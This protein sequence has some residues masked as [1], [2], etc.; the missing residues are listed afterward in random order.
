MDVKGTIHSHSLGHKVKRKEL[1]SPIQFEVDFS[2]TQCVIRLD[3]PKGHGAYISWG[4]GQSSTARGEGDI[5]PRALI[6]TSN[7]TTHKKYKV[8]LF[9]CFHRISRLDLTGVA[10]QPFLTADTTNWGLMESLKV[11]AAS[12]T[13]FTGTQPD[14][15][16]FKKL[17]ILDMSYLDLPVDLADLA[18][19]NKLKLVRFNHTNAICGS[20][21]PWDS[22][23]RM[24]L[25]LQDNNMDSTSVDNLL[26]A[27]AASI[28]TSSTIWLGG[29]NAALSHDALD[30]RTV[31]SAAAR[32]NKLIVNM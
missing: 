21:T 2:G 11:I 14:W 10:G 15:S 1:I 5:S 22:K 17:F 23:T 26:N 31:L 9:G 25:L 12:R 16:V 24:I 30:A 13:K 20:A 3:M 29:N 8:Q 27:Y 18:P 6:C 28:V 4:N 7:Y 19:L 32:K